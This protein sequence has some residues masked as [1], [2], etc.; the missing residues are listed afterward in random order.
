VTAPAL[1][2]PNLL[3]HS[4]APFP[5]SAIDV[6][7]SAGFLSN[8]TGHFALHLRDDDDYHL[9]VRD[10]L[11]V[12]K[13]FYAVAPDGSV[14]SA[15]YA[16]DLLRAGHPITRIQSVPLGHLVRIS[17][18]RRAFALEKY[19]HLA[20]ADA[21]HDAPHDLTTHGTRIRTSLETTFRALAQAFAGRPVYVTMSGGLDSTGI[22]VL[23]KEFLGDFV[24][25]TFRVDGGPA[26][27]E[28]KDDLHF[29]RT[30]AQ[31]LGVRFEVVTVPRNNLLSLV[32]SALVDGQD[33]RDFNVHCGL[34]NVALADALKDRFGSSWTTPPVV[35]TGDTM[36]EIMADYSPVA[37][38]AREYYG[39]P[40]VSIGRMRRILI[41]GLD[42]GDREV[43]IFARRG[44]QTI[45]PYAMCADAYCRVPAGLL[46]EQTAKQRLAR[47]IFG[48]RIPAPIYARPKVRAQVGSSEEVGGT[49][50]ALVDQGIDAAALE[51]RF[52]ELH[53]LQPADL[54]AWIRGGYYRFSSVYP[55]ED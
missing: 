35:L 15:N 29:A 3:L 17:P 10:P 50:A 9:L 48:D 18:S 52:C 22:A 40:R 47:A 5:V 19:A 12:N 31:A 45:Q 13:L 54:K 2:L 39:L 21:E 37:Y 44:I 55:L 11:G 28:V 46:S 4:G 36:N 38:G 30:V 51:R 6:P 43:G 20:F 14:S 1:A 32:D 33:Y 8:V 49:L 24:G 27:G 26:A 25:V 7:T 41:S 53:G 34:V 23:A 16:I 42:S